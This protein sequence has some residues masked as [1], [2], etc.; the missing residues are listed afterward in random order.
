MLTKE[1]FGP[2]PPP[3]DWFEKKHHVESRFQDFSAQSF[4]R[5]NSKGVF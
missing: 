1:D 3:L 5:T 2:K 4:P